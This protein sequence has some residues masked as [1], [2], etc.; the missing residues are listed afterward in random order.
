SERFN[1][2]P[3]LVLAFVR[4]NLAHFWPGITIDHYRKIKA[5]ALGGKRFSATTEISDRQADGDKIENRDSKRI[6]EPRLL[7][8]LLILAAQQTRARMKRPL[9]WT[10]TWPLA[11]RSATAATVSLLLLVQELTATM[12]SPRESLVRGFRIWRFLFISCPFRFVATLMPSVIVNISSMP[13]CTYSILMHFK[14]DRRATL[15]FNFRTLRS[16]TGWKTPTRK[17]DC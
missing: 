1:F 4:P 14:T 2:E 5:S 11:K 13:E 8:A 7:R 12:R 17:I 15:L 6:R 10:R 3:N 16:W 9:F